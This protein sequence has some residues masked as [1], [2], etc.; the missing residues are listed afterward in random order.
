M[1]VTFVTCLFHIYNMN[2]DDNKNIKWRVERFKE[3]L[4]TDIHICI[5]V[6]PTLEPIIRSLEQQYENLRIMKVVK[7][8]ELWVYKE[9]V[10]YNFT[11][12]EQ[13]NLLKDTPNYMFV[14][15][16][17]PEF[18][19]HAV[20][21]N[22]WNTSHFAWVDF[23]ITY[24]FKDKITSL[25]FFKDMEHHTW[26]PSCFL[27]PGCWNRHVNIH[28]KH[29]TECVHWRFCGGFLLGDAES[30][31][32]FHHLCTTEYPKF[33]KT[34]KK[35]VWEVNFWAWL[36]MNTL[37]NPDHYKADHDDSIIRA[38]SPSNYAL[39]LNDLGT[40]QQIYDYPR[41]NGYNP[42]SASY[43][44][45]RGKHY[46][47]TRYVS[48]WCCDNGSYM[49]Y[50][51]TNIIRTK[52]ITS[53]LDCDASGFLIPLNY[54]EMTETIKLAKYDLYSRGIEDIRLYEH[55]G[56]L[57][58]IATT[59][60]YYSTGGNRMIIGDYNYETKNYSNSHIIEPPTNTRC[61][62][63]WIPVTDPEGLGRE[64]FIYKWAPFEI[65]KIF[66]AP[67]K[68]PQLKI[69]QSFNETCGV[70]EFQHMKGSTTFID[71][72]PDELVGVVHFSEDTKPRSYFHMMVVL[73]KMTLKPLRYSEPFVFE[74]VGIE[75][76][77]GFRIHNGNYEFW[78]SRMDREPVLVRIC[79]D[80]LKIHLVFICE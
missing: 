64:L 28:C 31:Q 30:I 43:I 6:C 62:K 69:V 60:G 78:I 11:L 34:Y 41:I 3:L 59:V 36:E 49:F 9:T 29:V 74:K 15:N 21:E 26:K 17:K 38:I 54:H 1:T 33:I 13:R 77:I 19:N 66:R 4:N 51:G 53:E 56:L 27:I 40:V 42:G 73:D 32:R 45:Y 8:E 25:R 71:F 68:N 7:I 46:L 18:L 76:C 48:Y 61:E 35:L 58:Y 80:L 22:P 57:K 63:N 55:D 75:F 37:W 2:Y 39:N 70:H 65:G 72:G 52:N 20:Q 5:Y 16:S 79:C 14:M 24:I 67:D 50:D 44:F 12:P 47:N 10:K 23:N